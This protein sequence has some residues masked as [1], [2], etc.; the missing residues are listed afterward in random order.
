MDGRRCALT[1]SARIGAPVARLRQTPSTTCAVSRRCRRAC[2]GRATSASQV[3]STKCGI[4]P[5]WLTAFAV[6]TNVIAGRMTSSLGFTPSS[7]NATCSA[8]VPLTIAMAWRAS[9]AEAI[10]CRTG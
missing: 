2:P 7:N 5:V 8:A 10:I 6:A 1:T 4:A 3:K 9:V